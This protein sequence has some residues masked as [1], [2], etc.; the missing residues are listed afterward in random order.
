MSNPFQSKSKCVD[1]DPSYL[2]VDNKWDVKGYERIIKET[3][4]KQWTFFSDVPQEIAAAQKAG[5]KGYVLAREGNK[6]LT[7]E[8]K[9]NY[10]VISSFLEVK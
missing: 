6:P 1:F 5:M 9:K 4:I 7:D 2:G 3:G 8:E 10:K